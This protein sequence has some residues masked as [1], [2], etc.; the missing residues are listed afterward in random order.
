MRET[1]TSGSVEGVLSN[2]HPY[3]D[4]FRAPDPMTQRRTCVVLP[5][6]C[7]RRGMSLQA[8]RLS[9]KIA[10]CCVCIEIRKSTRPA[11]VVCCGRDQKDV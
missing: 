8:R 6:A 1:R 10:K 2:G 9:E 11:L 5:F 3:S 4:S 7:V